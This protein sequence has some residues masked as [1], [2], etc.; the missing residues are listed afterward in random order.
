M[1]N[2]KNEYQDKATDEAWPFAKIGGCM[3]AK[4]FLWK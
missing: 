2:E 1:R 4:T 3:M